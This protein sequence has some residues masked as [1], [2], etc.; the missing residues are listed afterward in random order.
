MSLRNVLFIHQSAEMYGS[1]KVLLSLVVALDRSKFNPIVILPSE[2]P[3]L[4]ALKEAGVR[5]H[6]VPLLRAN[7]A[8]LSLNGLFK[9][10]KS[11]WQSVRAISKAVESDQIHLVHSNTLAV[12]SGAIWAL[13]KGIPHVWHV[14]E[15]IERPL[16]VRKMYG[17]LL[18]LLA[19][20]IVC[21]SHATMNLLLQDQ[22]CLKSKAVV[23]WNG[24][25][26]EHAVNLVSAEVF[27]NSIGV[28][29]TDVL[30][31]LLGRINR[32]KG[33][34]LLVDAAEALE[35]R[36]VQN[37]HY[38]V[39]GSPP[40]GQEH[41]LYQL[42][43][44]LNGATVQSKVSLIPYTPDIWTVWDAC[45][46]AVVPSIEPEP[47]GM[48]ALEAMSAGKPV[49]AANHG[50]LAEI[51]VHNQTGILFEPGSVYDFA[52]AIESLAVDKDRR[53]SLGKCGFERAVRV[54]SLNQYA[55]G[56]E[57]CY[58]DLVS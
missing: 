38:V 3:L 14:H 58:D 52:G 23:V 34:G 6:I 4:V 30:V 54:F 19:N 28:A 32:W 2:G 26:R 53:A 13:L 5:C 50:G 56:I 40:G 18:R 41:F 42:Q 51:V 8:T 46:I 35:Q 24:I 44:R 48:V 57:R 36:G 33:Q 7:R 37:L 1:D 29:N 25:E 12:L 22:P 39:L 49:I 16:V 20:R 43:K 31:A 55:S 47:F 17:W 15:I 10:P 27:R 9:F 45:D 21:N 11:A